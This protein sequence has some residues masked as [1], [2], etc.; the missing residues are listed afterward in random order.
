MKLAGFE[1]T[2]GGPGLLAA[3]RRRCACAAVLVIAASIIAS[4]QTARTSRL[5][6]QVSMMCSSA[7]DLI[8]CF[9]NSPT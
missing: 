3:G 7:F 9:V 1:C 4:T 6:Q 8:D 2:A 5:V